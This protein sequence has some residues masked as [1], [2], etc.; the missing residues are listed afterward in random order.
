MPRTLLLAVLALAV[1]S[2]ILPTDRAWAR[3][4]WFSLTARIPVGQAPGSVALADLNRDGHLDIIVANEQGHSLTT[5]LGA[6]TGRFTE[7]PGSPVS[8]GHKPND[9]AVTDFDGDGA[10]DLAVANHEADYLTVLLGDGRWRFRPAPGSPVR[11]RVR[12]H[13]HGVAAADFNGDGHADLVTDGWETDE[14]EILLGDGR[15]GFSHHAIE[16]VGRH[17]YQRVRAWDANG[18][19]HADVVTANLRG[20]SL[21]MLL[22]DGRGGFRNAPGSPFAAHPF[23]TAVARGDFNFDQAVAN[24]PSNSAGQGQDGL[25]VLVADGSGGFPSVEASPVPTGAAPTQLAVGDLDGDGRDEVAVSNMNSGTVSLARLG[26][27]GRLVVTEH[28]RVGRL[29]K[30][31]AVG[32]LNGDRKPDLVVANNGDDDLAILLAR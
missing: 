24:S 30:G 32:D 12:P 11:V 2:H 1:V 19:G 3:A 18:D 20:A 15:G 14:A 22:G 26:T 31:I 27:G 5:L 25:T 28:F 4:P 16:R 8:A 21:T 13:P 29:P 17:P 9:I 10:L 23:P 7:T 6:G